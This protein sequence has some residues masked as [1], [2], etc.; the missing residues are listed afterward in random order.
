MVLKNFA[1]WKEKLFGP[2]SLAHKRQSGL[3]H[4]TQPS[5]FYTYLGIAFNQINF[6]VDK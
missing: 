3:A 5:S 4:L 6:A 2:N 1:G